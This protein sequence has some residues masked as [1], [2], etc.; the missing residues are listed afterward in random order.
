MKKKKVKGVEAWA[1]FRGNKIV[2]SDFDFLEIAE[3][4]KTLLKDKEE[5]ACL[6]ENTK[7][8]PVLITPI[9]NKVSKK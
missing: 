7:V 6:F 4:R 9:I 5:Y 1:T 2:Y 8:I 3:S